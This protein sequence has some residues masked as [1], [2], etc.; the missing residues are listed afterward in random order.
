MGGIAKNPWEV[1]LE[2]HGEGLVYPLQDL[3]Q[4]QDLSLSTVT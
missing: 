4:A 1:G 2:V 3:P